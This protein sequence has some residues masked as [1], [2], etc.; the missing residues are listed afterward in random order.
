MAFNAMKMQVLSEIGFDRQKKPQRTLDPAA[1]AYF[2]PI[3]RLKA[4]ATAR[5]QS[6]AARKLSTRASGVCSGG[7]SS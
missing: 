3:D 7:R 1:R 2:H 5:I 6:A 4:Y